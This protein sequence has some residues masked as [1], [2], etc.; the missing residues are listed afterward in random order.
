MSG[1]YIKIVGSDNTINKLDIENEIINTTSPYD[2]NL[3]ILSAKNST[4][5]NLLL[6]NNN[7]ANL[8]TLSSSN[9]TFNIISNFVDNLVTFSKDQTFFNSKKNIFSG[10]INIDSISANS[11]ITIAGLNNID[12]FNVTSNTYCNVLKA[13]FDNFLILKGNIGIGTTSPQKP[14]HVNG[15]ALINNV[16]TNTLYNN[17]NSINLNDQG[18]LR[19]NAQITS[20]PGTLIAP[21]LNLGNTP[22]SVPS[23]T[24]PNIYSSNIYTSLLYLDNYTVASQSNV[25]G[26]ILSIVNSNIIHHSSNINS[27]IINIYTYTSNA[28]ANLGLQ[29]TLIL[30]KYGQM[31]FGSSNLA[32]GVIDIANN[33]NYPSCNI[34]YISTKQ[35]SN[36][37]VID[38]NANIGIGTIFPLHSLHIV[39]NSNINY[40]SLVGLYSSN[41]NS[42]YITINSNSIPIVNLSSKG[43]LVIGNINITDNYNIDLASNLRSPSIYTDNLYNINILNQN[44]NFNTAGIS[45]ISSGYI[46]CNLY[47]NS[48]INTSNINTTSIHTDTLIATNFETS[49]VTIANLEITATT[50]KT[51][52]TDISQFNASNQFIS[53]ASNVLFTKYT[54][55]DGLNIP[56]NNQKMLITSA[57]GYSS[58]TFVGLNISSSG[59]STTVS[60]RVSGIKQAIFESYIYNSGSP[61]VFSKYCQFGIFNDG[62]GAAEYP[63]NFIYGS[64]PDNS[65]NYQ[66]VTYKIT[67]QYY[68]IYDYFRM[69]NNNSSDRSIN[70]SSSGGPSKVYINL[71]Q[72]TDSSSFDLNLH[73]NGKVG[74]TSTAATFP[75][76]YYSGRKLIG[77]VPYDWVGIGITSDNTNIDGTYKF[78]VNGKSSLTDVY[79]SGNVGIGT[80]ISLPTV[81]VLHVWGTS[82]FN[83]GNV[84]IGIGTTTTAQ[85]TLDVNG[86]INFNGK[87]FNNQQAY[88]G[89]QWTTNTTAGYTT[90]VYYYP[91]NT[92]GNVGIGTTNTSFRLNVNGPVNFSSNLTVAGT[93]TAGNIAS[94]SDIRLKEN[95]EKISGAVNII[96]EISGYYYNRTDIPNNPRECGCIAQEV[97]NVLPEVVYTNNDKLSISYG[98]MAA[99]FTEAIKEIDVR[100]EKI[101]KYLNIS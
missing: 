74:F 98:N 68:Q 100:L 2:S 58:P 89:S 63:F 12:Y 38:N 78:L 76:L 86:D 96:K 18:T 94:T 21:G 6:Y 5:A 72:I 42:S 56:I 77:N 101:E 80:A 16:Y 32:R 39:N 99:L 66:P 97:Q 48:N 35:N 55:V 46:N 61:P 9:A 67:D 43:N 30:D 79:A 51:L 29:P 70:I 90:D 26:N 36:N 37:F 41:L 47:V 50:F 53:Y 27:N 33:S 22:L 57:A 8:I 65:T 14:L 34:L 85:K 23:L 45:N 4:Q 82:T 93:V 28:S 15:D 17:Q 88:I 52:S 83:N 3:A 13:N 62:G 84:G 10:T 73:V 59:P 71:N 75:T 40:K 54:T 11:N 24:A 95:I 81:A 31:I 64:T 49:H 44:I 60:N 19:I 91:N 7:K 92:I 20:I 87:L 1:A 69:K 25:Y